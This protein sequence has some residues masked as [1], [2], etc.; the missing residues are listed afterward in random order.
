MKK[1]N[2]YIKVSAICPRCTR[3]DTR[4]DGKKSMLKCKVC[5]Y[6]G[7][8]SQFIEGHSARKVVQELFTKWRETGDEE[9]LKGDPLL[10]GAEKPLKEKK[11]A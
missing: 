8:W 10:G 7:H 1:N 3:E 2:V 9:K 4:A 5:G 6:G 11:I